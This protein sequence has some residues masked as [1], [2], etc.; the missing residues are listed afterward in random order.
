MLRR[1]ITVLIVV[2]CAAGVVTYQM[3]R[4]ARTSANPRPFVP[5]PTF[6][7]DFSPSFRTSIADA[8]YLGMMQYYGT[9]HRNTGKLSSLPAMT[10]LVTSLSPKFATAYF[11]GSFALVDAGHPEWGYALLEKGFEEN[12]KDWRFPIMLGF[13]AYHYGTGDGK[14][15]D[16]ARWY[17]EAAAIQGS[18]DYVSRLAAVLLGK[19]GEKEKAVLLWGQVYVEGDK[20]SREKAVSGLDRILPKD[21]T[22]RMKAVAP[23]YATMPKDDFEA[24]IAELFKGYVQ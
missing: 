17:Q 15:L 12:P 8:Y 6:F 21:K 22:A 23:L 3:T 1:A 13:F 10:D 14:A 7:L 19:G 11:F 2:A 24:L 20:Y 5:S 9:Y 4:P 18:P 16:A